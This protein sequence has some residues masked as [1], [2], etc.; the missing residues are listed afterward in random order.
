MS[1]EPVKLRELLLDVFT[2][3]SVMRHGVGRLDICDREHFERAITAAELALDE[4][5][6]MRRSL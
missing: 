5:E 4:I 3:L 6:R 1:L 2:E